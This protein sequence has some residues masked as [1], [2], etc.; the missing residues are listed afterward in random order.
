M[1][2]VVRVV[3]MVVLPDQPLLKDGLTLTSFVVYYFVPSSK[4]PALL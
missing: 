2:Y 4:K 3:T 1:F